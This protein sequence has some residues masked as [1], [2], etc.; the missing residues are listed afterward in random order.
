MLTWNIDFVQWE[1]CIDSFMQEATWLTIGYIPS[2][3]DYLKNGKVSS[4]SRVVTLQ[5]ILSLDV[6]IY[7]D[8]IKEI[9]YPSKFNDLLCLASD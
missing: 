2:V 9:D 3:E 1:A 8:I 5:P 7:D 6:P 4:G